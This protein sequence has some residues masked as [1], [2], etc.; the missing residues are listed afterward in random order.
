MRIRRATPSWKRLMVEYVVMVSVY[1]LVWHVVKGQIVP[2]VVAL[3]LTLVLLRFARPKVKLPPTP[4]A[5]N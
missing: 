4:P 3:I 2:S 1:L 5:A